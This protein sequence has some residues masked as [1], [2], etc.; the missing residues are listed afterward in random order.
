MQYNIYEFKRE[1]AGTKNHRVNSKKGIIHDLP[2]DYDEV[3]KITGAEYVQ[4]LNR[5]GIAMLPYEEV[6]RKPLP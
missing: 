5:D 1:K 4:Y 6:R 3:T 2:F